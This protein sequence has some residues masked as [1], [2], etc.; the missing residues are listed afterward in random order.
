M[1][2]RTQEFVDKHTNRNELAQSIR[3]KIDTEIRLLGVISERNGVPERNLV[4]ALFDEIEKAVKEAKA[5]Y[6]KSNK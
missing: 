6:E 3:E 5:D 2:K 4:Q 1:T